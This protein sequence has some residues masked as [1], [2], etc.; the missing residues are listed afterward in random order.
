[1]ASNYILGGHYSYPS[2]PRSAN[3]DDRQEAFKQSASKLI[4]SQARPNGLA[5]RP[6]TSD[7]S[8]SS[9]TTNM[10]ST[11]VK[12]AQEQVLQCNLSK[13]PT[14]PLLSSEEF[15]ARVD[16]IIESGQTQPGPNDIGLRGK[17]TFAEFL[18][19]QACL[20]VADAR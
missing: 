18:E 7:K 11:H 2:R 12:E 16:K 20:E 4:G 10:I 9:K 14:P 6:A 19:T 5:A 13:D 15:R 8:A 3:N 1:M 17:I